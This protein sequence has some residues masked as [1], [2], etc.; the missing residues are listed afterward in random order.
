MKEIPALGMTTPR[1]KKKAKKADYVLALKENHPTLRAEVILSFEEKPCYDFY[2]TI[3]YGDG[4]IEI[5]KCSI[6]KYLNYIF[7]RNS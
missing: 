4:R 7:D 5:R 2:Q 6:I 1:R 3:E